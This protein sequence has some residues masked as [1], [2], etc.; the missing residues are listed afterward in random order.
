MARN[1]EI[2]RPQRM[3]HGTGHSEFCTVNL[4]KEIGKEFQILVKAYSETFGER[5]TPT[6][7]IKRFIDVGLK[8]CDPDVYETFVNMRAEGNADPV[9]EITYQTAEG[10][11]DP[12]EGNVWEMRYFAEKDGEQ[13]ELQVGDKQPFYGKLNGKDVGLWKFIQE[14][15]RCMNEDGVEINEEQAKV[16]AQKI[17]KHLL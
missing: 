10:T 17:K 2:Y 1:K 15:Y 9:L 11:P 13:V 14:G 12:T 16:I 8:R 7:I 5:V 4:R 6:Q 3:A